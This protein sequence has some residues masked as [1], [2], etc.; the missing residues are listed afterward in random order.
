M[1]QELLKL[2]Q[3]GDIDGLESRCLELLE[4][5]SPPLAQMGK[6]FELLSQSEQASR[7]PAIAQTVLDNIEVDADPK[8]TLH[9]VRSALIAAPKD[10]ELRKRTVDLYT[11]VYGEVPGFAAILDSSGLS[12]GRAARSAI[13]VLDLCLTL[14]VGDVL[15]SRMDDKA[16]EVTTVDREHGLFTLKREGRITTLPAREVVREYDRVDAD[17]FRVL[18]Q[19]RPEKLQEML[20]NDPVAVVVGLI[21]AHGEWIDSDRLKDELVPKYIPAKQWTKW[22]GKAR[23]ELKRSQHVT[24]EGRSPLILTYNESARTLEDETWE[25]FGSRDDALHWMSVIEGYLREKAALKEVP[26]PD[27]LTRCHGHIV[28]YIESIRGRRPGEALACALVIDRLAEKGLPTTDWSRSLGTEMLGES[29]KPVA[30]FDELG[31]TVLVDRALALLPEARPA[32]WLDHVIG[33]VPKAVAGQL[34]WIAQQALKHERAADIQRYIDDA[35][36]DP[37]G[38][39]EVVYWL[40]KGPK[41]HGGLTLPDPLP[42]FHLI[43]DALSGIG[44]TGTTDEEAVKNFRA[45][46]KAAF[47]LRSFAKVGACCSEMSAASAVTV[48]RQLERMDGLGDTAPSKMLNLLRESHPELWIKKTRQLE[49]WEDPDVAWVTEAGLKRKTEERDELVN[50]KMRENAQRIGEAASHGD[51]SENSEY[52]FA[53]E[54]RDLLRARLAQMNKD[55][56]QAETFTAADVP[57]DYIGI[58]SRVRFLDVEADTERW[59]TFLGPFETD[60]EA[61]IYSYRAPLS[62]KVMGLCVGQLATVTLDGEE[63]HLE[64]LEIR[65]G[66]SA[67][68]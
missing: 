7:I 48:R 19:L 68:P 35:L 63:H 65:N 11:R 21:H 60:V 39:P 52:K 27:F 41:H 20:E 14:D 61:G 24:V 36:A 44:R 37:I 51:L 56:S 22:W 45:R 17:D 23:T 50:V 59:I 67:S 1:P 26:D 62:Q 6:A 54:E 9:V 15:I 58:G 16:I 5:G 28:S 34:D 13:K 43:M 31:K 8:G 40:W 30:L 46:M 29:S 38:S 55:L 3:K 10:D 33:Y 18:R 49:R 47:S 4:N 2:A 32:D 25:N 57:E 53:L 12:S 64:V 42:F 66:L